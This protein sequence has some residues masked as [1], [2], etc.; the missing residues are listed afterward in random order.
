VA[1]ARHA[2]EMESTLLATMAW[3]W[4]AITG[5]VL[6]RLGHT[7]GP[8]ADVPWPRIWWCPTGPLTLLP[9]HAAGHQDDRAVAER[10]VSSYAPSLR[11]LIEARRAVT[12]P[13]D[14]DLG[15]LVVAMPATAGQAP[16]PNAIRERD[17]LTRLFPRHSTVLTG[18]AASRSAVLSALP[19]HRWAHFSCH[20]DQDLAEPS[21][22]G[23]LLADGT[24]TVADIGDGRYQGEFAFLSACK[25]GTGGVTLIDEAITLAA[26]LQY[27]GYRHVVATSWSVY[28]ATAVEVAENVYGRLA[29]NG[30][31]H[32]AHAALALHG[33]IRRLRHQF[34]G[35]PSV[36]MPFIHL[37]P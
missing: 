24:L 13:L 36:W 15:L 8:A 34:P 4:D 35:R 31:L 26:A 9:L 33:A 17:L 23:L 3:L 30:L 32:P 19:V 29:G 28:D 10:A 5:P 7:A 2:E 37:G 22:G 25:T 16:L 11:A 14:D 12:G 21:R 27:A 6:D 20:G 18:P 1:L